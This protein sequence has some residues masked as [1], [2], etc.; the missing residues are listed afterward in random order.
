MQQLLI[1][2]TDAY[3]SIGLLA[4][5]AA[6]RYAQSLTNPIT[7]CLPYPKRVPFYR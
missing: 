6:N 2:H 4:G 3:L 1:T 7:Q 5:A